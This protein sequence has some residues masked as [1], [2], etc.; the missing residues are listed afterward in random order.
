MKISVHDKK[1]SFGEMVE[2]RG[3]EGI[4]TQEWICYTRNSVSVARTR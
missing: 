4:K 2:V 3:V 1:Q